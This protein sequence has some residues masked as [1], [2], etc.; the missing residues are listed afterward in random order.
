[1]L[2]KS[3][4][5]LIDVLAKYDLGEDLAMTLPSGLSDEQ[6][7]ILAEYICEKMG[8]NRNFAIGD[9]IRAK[10]ILMGRIEVEE[11]DE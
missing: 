6:M 7:D 2:T 1:M 3:E 4:E 8:T 11:E 5:N 10:L 9:I